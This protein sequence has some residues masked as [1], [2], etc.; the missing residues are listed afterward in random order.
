MVSP[1][2]KN[3]SPVSNTQRATAPGSAN[4][5]NLSDSSIDSIKWSNR[6]PKKN[7]VKQ[8]I[9]GIR[10]FLKNVTT[11]GRRKASAITAASAVS[12]TG[13][14]EP[15]IMNFERSDSLFINPTPRERELVLKQLNYAQSIMMRDDTSYRISPQGIS[16]I[17]R[18]GTTRLL[19]DL[20]AVRN[21]PDLTLKS[22]VTIE[23]FIDRDHLDDR[24]EPI[25][26]VKKTIRRGEMSSFKNILNE[27]INT[28]AL[29]GAGNANVAR[30]KEIVILKEESEVVIL[31]E[32]VEGIGLP[33]RERVDDHTYFPKSMMTVPDRH[34]GNYGFH[35]GVV[36]HIDFEGATGQPTYAAAQQNRLIMEIEQADGKPI[37][38]RKPSANVVLTNQT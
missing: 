33:V 15:F 28:F 11:P 34:P 35:K 21:P 13:S 10:S 6:L 29:T 14:N 18:F 8:S 9:K 1:I 38:S 36:T 37:H 26:L 19:G 16:P 17:P 7:L 5:E 30:V 20:E 4:L 3:P 12:S 24:G 31:S 2:R 23:F 27:A 25:G 22:N 32:H